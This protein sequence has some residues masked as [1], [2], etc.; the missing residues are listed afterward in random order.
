LSIRVCCFEAFS[1]IIP[2]AVEPLPTMT[3]H[4]LPDLESE[5]AKRSLTALG[6]FLD[7]L[8]RLSS[9]A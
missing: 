2:A 1:S 9:L 4:A 7:M 8:G 5:D 3:M 6:Y